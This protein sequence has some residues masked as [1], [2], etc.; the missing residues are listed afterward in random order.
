MKN[1]W[2]IVPVK[3]LNR[4]KSRLS[5]VLSIKQ[6]E[7]LSR[8]MLERTLRLLQQVKG[9]GGIMVVSRD[10]Y[11]L[12]LARKLDVQTLQE[13]GTPDLNNS[14]TR[15]T[16]VVSTWNAGGV[17]ILASDIP[18]IQ[19]DDLERMI[20][21]ADSAKSVVIAPDRRGTGTNALLVR[22]PGLITYHFGVESFPRHHSEA[23]AA[24]ASL[25]VYRSPTVGLD[26]DTPADLDLYREMLVEQEMN[27]PAWLAST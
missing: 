23:E 8:D 11:A 26:V 14:L 16:Q 25:H 10:T 6:R 17:L 20:G 22:P 5:P 24:E 7:T 18:L 19:V 13:S 27:E 12:S 9:F 3:P 4:S 21:L 1:I 2:A 15:A